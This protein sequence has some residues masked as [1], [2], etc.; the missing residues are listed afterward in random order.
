MSGCCPATCGCGPALSTCSLAMCGCVSG[1]S[2]HN[3][4]RDTGTEYAEYPTPSSKLRACSAIREG[5]RMSLVGL[6]LGWFA[7]RH[8]NRAPGK[9]GGSASSRNQALNE[10]W[11]QNRTTL[12]PEFLLLLCQSLTCL[13]AETPA[14]HQNLHDTTVKRGTR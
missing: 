1:C 3:M 5:P 8:F 4:V 9:A 2:I 14:T 7:L 12:Y 13:Q 10:G 6:G 11:R